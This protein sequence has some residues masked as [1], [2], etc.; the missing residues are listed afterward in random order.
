MSS[1]IPFRQAGLFHLLLAWLERPSL[2]LPASYCM[3][4]SSSVGYGGGGNTLA[5]KLPCQADTGACHTLG[6]DT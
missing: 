2:G 5:Y 3:R 4:Q 1:D 6:D